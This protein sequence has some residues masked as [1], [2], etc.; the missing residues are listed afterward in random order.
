[1]YFYT[2]N[3]H[4]ICTIQLNKRKAFY[5]LNNYAKIIILNEGSHTRLIQYLKNSQSDIKTL[6]QATRKT[7]R[8]N[9][10]IRYVWLETSVYT[11]ITFARSLWTMVHT[12]VSHI[13]FGETGPIGQFFIE[14]KIDIHKNLYE[15]YFCY[16][17]DLEK[18]LSFDDGFWGRKY[19]LRQKNHADIII[20]E[21]FSPQIVILSDKKHNK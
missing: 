15:L 21:F 20:Q 6:Q 17:K 13:N 9:R 7:I 14:N 16:C 1:M 5:Y 18:T 2:N 8:S 10:K 12:T 3:F 4:L 19:L 11:N